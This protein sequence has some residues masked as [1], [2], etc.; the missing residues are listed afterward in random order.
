MALP[1]SAHATH[2]PNSNGEQRRRWIE[3][4]IPGERQRLHDLIMAAGI[5]S[6]PDVLP[7]A[8]EM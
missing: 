7:E 5:A 2:Q 3:A 4:V 1:F 8:R 6:K